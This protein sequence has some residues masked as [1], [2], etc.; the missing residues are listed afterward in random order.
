M[1]LQQNHFR[2]ALRAGKPQ[3]G[4]WIALADANVAEAIAGAGFDWLLFDAEH[5]PNDPRTVLEQL[6][7]AAAYPV[8]CVVRPVQADPA[9]VKQYL[10]IG[11]QTVLIPMI[12]TREQAELM[13]QAMRYPPEGIRGMGPALARASRWNQIEDYVNL[14]NAQT[15]LLVQAET[16]QAMRRLNEIANVAGVD[17]VFFGP[18]DLSASMGLRGQPNHA[19]VQ[20]AIIDGIAIVRAAGKAAGVLS[21]DRECAKR[22]LHAGAQFVAVGSDATLLVQAAR[23]LVRTFKPE[24]GPT[25]PQTT[26]AY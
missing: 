3:I 12:D 25:A 4:L 11:A 19:E 14:A 21:T 22:Y 10:D 9:L 26:S 15:C 16:P 18:V 24:D 20:R 13:V 23:E 2:D 8:H 7:A 17:G 1:K 6:R 5:G